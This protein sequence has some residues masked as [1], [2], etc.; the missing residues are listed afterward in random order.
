MILT[1]STFVEEPFTHLPFNRATG[2]PDLFHDSP[3][4]KYFGA[5]AGKLTL[6][7]E[8]HHH[9]DVCL[10]SFKS[11]VQ[12]VQ[13]FQCKIESFVLEL[14]AARCEKIDCLIEVEGI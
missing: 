7:H 3:R 1:D 6:R 11:L 12:P 2:L 8:E 5:D 13:R 14:V 4:L 10:L 9:G